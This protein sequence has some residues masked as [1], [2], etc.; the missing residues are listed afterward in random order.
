MCSSDL[1]VAFTAAWA[2]EDAK[3]RKRIVAGRA[4]LPQVVVPDAVLEHTA[5]LCMALGTDGLRGELTVMRAAR[6]LAAPRT[7]GK[8]T[9]HPSRRRARLTWSGV[10]AGP[11]L[12]RARASYCVRTTA[13]VPV[14]VASSCARA[15]WN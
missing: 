10:S 12:S 9:E 1:P 2:K 5:R 7:S 15:W 4:L 8:R 14:S 6:A 13:S 3:I 11:P